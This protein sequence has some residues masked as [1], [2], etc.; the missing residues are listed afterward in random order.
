MTSGQGFKLIC[1]LIYGIIVAALTVAGRIYIGD[2]PHAEVARAVLE[3]QIVTDADLRPVGQKD[4]SGHFALR[5]FAVGQKITA[6]DVSPPSTPPLDNTVAVVITM[7]RLRDGGAIE[8]GASVQVC[9]DRKPSGKPGKVAMSICGDKNCLV[10][11]PL[12]EWLIDTKGIKDFTGSAEPR[13]TAL[14]VDSSRLSA[15]AEG[16][17]C[18]G[19]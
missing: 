14:P 12:G 19:T 8:K 16:E 1:V 2:G 15:V 7:R 4:I 9:L 13:P 18:D 6:R 11:I 17:K 3:N 10:T 5:G